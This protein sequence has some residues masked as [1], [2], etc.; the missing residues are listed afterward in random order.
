MMRDRGLQEE[1]IPLAGE[2][3]L[4]L[5]FFPQG[6][7]HCGRPR[8]PSERSALPDEMETCSN[9]GF[10]S[11]GRSVRVDGLLWRGDLWVCVNEL[12]S[13]QKIWYPACWQLIAF[14]L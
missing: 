3:P 12:V 13:H 2:R 14:G 7:C 10:W 4:A 9:H 1:I 6:T 5:S 11:G 8:E